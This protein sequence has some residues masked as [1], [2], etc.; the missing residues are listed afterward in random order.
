MSKWN[1]KSA[2]LSNSRNLPVSL[3]QRYQSPADVFNQLTNDIAVFQANSAAMN[4]L[5]LNMTQ[6]ERVKQ[7]NLI[8]DASGG[9]NLYHLFGYDRLSLS[10]A[11]LIEMLAFIQRWPETVVDIHFPE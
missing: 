3:R 1:G 10:K 5:Q 6:K 4:K 8:K 7:Y 2:F 9:R 11:Q